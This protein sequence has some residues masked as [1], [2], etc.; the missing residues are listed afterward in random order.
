MKRTI[1][2]NYNFVTDGCFFCYRAT[3]DLSDRFNI[4]DIFILNRIL[5]ELIV[6]SDTDDFEGYE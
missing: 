1:G 4:K 2:L 6:L 5:N 3:S